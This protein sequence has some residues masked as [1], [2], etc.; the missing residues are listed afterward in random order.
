MRYWHPLCTEGVVPPDHGG[1]GLGL[2]GLGVFW[3]GGKVLA[4]LYGTGFLLL[5]PS[6]LHSLRKSGWFMV[7]RSDFSSAKIQGASGRALDPCVLFSVL[8]GCLVGGLVGL[9]TWLKMRKK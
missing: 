8:V 1:A 3:Y 2:C 9:Y 5:V 7:Q 6:G 4:E